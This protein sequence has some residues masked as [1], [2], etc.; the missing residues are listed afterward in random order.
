MARDKQCTDKEPFQS[1]LDNLNRDVFIQALDDRVRYGWPLEQH[2]LDR[3]KIYARH[4]HPREPFD[5]IKAAAALIADV[6]AKRLPKVVA[7]L[8]GSPY[9]YVG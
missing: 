9:L 1:L 6:K 4:M 5:E 7:E 2:L 8:M 3:L